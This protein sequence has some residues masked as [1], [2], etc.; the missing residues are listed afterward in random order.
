MQPLEE[1][2]LHFKFTRENLKILLISR[3]RKAVFYLLL[4]TE[5]RFCID[6]IFHHLS[7]SYFANVYKFSTP[8][9]TLLPPLLQSCIKKKNTQRQSIHF[10]SFSFK[11]STVPDTYSFTALCS[12]R[13]IRIAKPLYYCIVWRIFQI[14]YS[15]YTC[16]IYIPN[17]KPIQILLIVK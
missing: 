1:W 11:T 6:N 12:F 3:C 5:H 15:V 16:Y 14:I 7:L 17:P 9:T 8:L 4:M 10:N 2:A 13:F